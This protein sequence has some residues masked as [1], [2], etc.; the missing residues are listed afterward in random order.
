[1]PNKTKIFFATKNKSKWDYFARWC[2]L[3]EYE[4][5]T[6]FNFDKS[7]WPEFEENGKT[8]EENAIIKAKNWSNVI[9]DIFVISNDCGVQIPALGE[10]WKEE[11]TRRQLGGNKTTDL[12]K[13]NI[14]LAM[15]KNLK[16]EERLIQWSDGIAIALNGKNLGSM[17][18]P[19]PVGYVIENL[20]PNPV[21]MAGAPL[22]TI[23]FKPDF[24]KVYSEMSETEIRKH[25]ERTIKEFQVFIKK[26]L[27][28]T[29]ERR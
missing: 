7:T 29:Y 14:L 22:A 2:E 6:P 26:S 16:G 19:S 21:I 11:F 15:M 23:E 13:I 18:V 5:F 24:G 9:K 10:N 1:M 17:T 12:E 25:D 4:R 3:V 8:L 28:Q 20:P 27:T